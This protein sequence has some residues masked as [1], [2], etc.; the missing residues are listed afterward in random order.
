M[1]FS[2]KITTFFDNLLSSPEPKTDYTSP[3]SQS[4]KSTHNVMG[5]SSIHSYKAELTDLKFTSSELLL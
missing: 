4:E 2:G 3:D 5:T 1:V